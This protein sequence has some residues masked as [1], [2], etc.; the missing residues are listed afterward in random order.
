MKY[1]SDKPGTGAK[2]TVMENPWGLNISV[3]HQPVFATQP[4]FIQSAWGYDL[5]PKMEGRYVKKPM[6]VCSL[7]KRHSS[8]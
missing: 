6:E 4:K 7:A 2:L 3:P 5:R 8:S 1:T